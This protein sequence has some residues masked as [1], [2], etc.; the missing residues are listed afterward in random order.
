MIPSAM[1]WLLALHLLLVPLVFSTHTV[2]AFEANKIALLLTTAVLV[3]ALALWSWLPRFDAL[4]SLRDDWISLGFVLLA[5]SALVSTIFSVSPL[6]SWRGDHAN[7]FGLRTV[8]AY[9][10]L[11]FATRHVC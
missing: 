5:L 7:G 8:L 1:R 2:E 11:F 6:L 4:P 10:V 3:G 9:L